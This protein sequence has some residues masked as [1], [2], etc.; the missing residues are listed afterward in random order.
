MQ[1]ELGKATV[2]VQE[3]ALLETQLKT[4][5]ATNSAEEQV[6]TYVYVGVGVCLQVLM[7]SWEWGGAG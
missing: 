1:R 3:L 7:C 2:Q 5:S 6:R 4:A